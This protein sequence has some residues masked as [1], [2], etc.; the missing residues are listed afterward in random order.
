[1]N[2]DVD[3]P[4]A[5]NFFTLFRRQVP[6]LVTSAYRRLDWVDFHD[7]FWSIKIEHIWSYFPKK[8]RMNIIK[9]S[10][11]FTLN[12]IIGCYHILLARVLR[13]SSF[14]QSVLIW[15]ASEFFPAPSKNLLVP[16][17]GDIHLWRLRT[18]YTNITM[19]VHYSRTP[20]NQQ[21]LNRPTRPYYSKLLKLWEK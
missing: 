3:F 16:S 18:H 13:I 6:C 1:M 21:H 9:S 7:L 4:T 2:I 8:I 17:N 15:M 10:R 14:T 5:F 19:F 12:W 11:A 20:A